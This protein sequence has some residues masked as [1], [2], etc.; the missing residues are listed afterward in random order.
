MSTLDRELDRE[1][2]EENGTRLSIKPL[3]VK[4]GVEIQGLDFSQPL[5]PKT[6]DLIQSLLLEKQFLSFP[7]QDLTPERLFEISELFGKPEVSPIWSGMS[8]N[9]AIIRATKQ[10]GGADPLLCDPQ[11][12]GSFYQRPS[13]FVFAY[14]DDESINADIICASMTEAWK[15]LSKPIQDF[16]TPLTAIHSASSVYAPS[17]KNAGL[18][19][20]ENCSQLAYSDAV[21]QTAEHP[22]VHTHPDTGLRSLFINQAHTESI[23][24]LAEIES[25]AILD[26]LWAHCA[27][28]DFGCRIVCYQKNF[29]IWD[30]RVTTI[31]LTE[32][33]KMKDRLLY[34]VA[35]GNEEGLNPSP[36]WPTTA[37]A[38]T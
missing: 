22:I 4:F 7:N 14:Y 30:N 23:K 15:A 2:R 13:K 8:E 1:A 9:P 25:R 3:G 18:Y 37:K 27:R 6:V 16:L 29:L 36:I 21:Y 17:R 12:F 35:T 20:G 34:L 26:F 19:V 11:T 10:A 32:Y 24:G 31:M 5:K 38:L 33:E 28:P